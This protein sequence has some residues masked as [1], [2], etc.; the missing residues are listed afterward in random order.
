MFRA[1]RTD[2]CHRR[3]RSAYTLAELLVVIAIIAVLIG[4]LI[5]AVQ[6]VRESA[7][8]AQCENQM[9]QTVLAAHNHESTKGYLPRNPSGSMPFY[10]RPGH[11]VG[12]GSCLWYLLPYMGQDALWRQDDA[13]DAIDAMVRVIGAPVPFYKC[14]SRGS[15]LVADIPPEWDGL[16]IQREIGGRPLRHGLSDYAMNRMIH[17]PPGAEPPR[18][19]TTSAHIRDGLSNTVLFAEKARGVWRQ[20]RPFWGYASSWSDTTEAQFNVTQDSRMVPDWVF[21]KVNVEHNYAV[22]GWPEHQVSANSAGS[23]HT[24]GGVVA[25]ADGSVRIVSYTITPAAWLALC[26]PGSGDRANFDD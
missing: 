4:L 2:R 8:R 3:H 6:K 18:S 21:T 1:R 10:D 14:P 25:A 5:P 9:R 16:D 19:K 26:T 13:A 20:P 11:P 23:A 12:G 15:P 24:T 22:T 7:A 17:D